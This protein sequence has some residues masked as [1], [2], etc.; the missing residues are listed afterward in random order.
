MVFSSMISPY[1]SPGAYATTLT[2][3]ETLLIMPRTDGVSCNSATELT[4]R[5]PRPRTVARCDSRVPIKP[6]T[7]CTLTVFAMMSA[8]T[9]DVFDRLAAFGGDVGSSAHFGQAVQRGAHQVVRVRRAGGF[10]HHVRHAHHFEDSAHGATSDHAGTRLG[11]VHHH[12]R[13]AMTAVDGVM[14]SA[15]FQRYF[16]QVATGF[17][18]CLLHTNRYFLRLALAHADAAIAVTN[19]GQRGETHDTTTLDHFGHTVDR[20]HFFAHA[21]IRL[22]ACHFCLHFCHDRSLE[23]QTG[24]TRGFCQ[25]LHTA[26]VTETG[27][28]KRDFGN[29][30]FQCFLCDALANQGSGGG[31]ATLARFAGQFVAHF[32]FCRGGRHQNFGIRRDQVRVDMQVSA[33]Y[34]QAVHF[35][36][37]D[38]DPGL[39]SATQTRF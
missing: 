36:L 28:V 21:V 33:V 3:Y 1:A 20:D 9:E 25:R 8:L 34:R 23:L 18:H 11:R 32:D 4:R 27:A 7:N 15:V 17:F 22:V 35:L 31:V 13:R 16:N 14:Q 12:F 2:R 6:L 39:A 26:V 10:R 38:L 5:R 24:F 37:R 19:H 30:C 29:P